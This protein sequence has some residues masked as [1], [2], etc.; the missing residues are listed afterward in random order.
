MR[1]T[2]DTVDITDVV[3]SKLIMFINGNNR[4]H[5]QGIRWLV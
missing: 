5:Q 2:L 4:I 1:L 3:K